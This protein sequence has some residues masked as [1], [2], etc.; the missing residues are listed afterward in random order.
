MSVKGCDHRDCN[1]PGPMGL[2]WG[3]STGLVQWYC[4]GHYRTALERMGRLLDT[5]RSAGTRAAH[6]EV[7]P[8]A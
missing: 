6:R 8:A 7:R 3:L 2:G 4:A 5:A 1:R